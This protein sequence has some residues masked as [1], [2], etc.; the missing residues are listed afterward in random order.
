[1]MLTPSFLSHVAGKHRVADDA[2]HGVFGPLAGLADIA[3][4]GAVALRRPAALVEQAGDGEL[5]S[6]HRFGAWVS[7]PASRRG[8][9]RRAYLGP[10]KTHL[11]PSLSERLFQETVLRHSGDSFRRLFGGLCQSPKNDGF[12]GHDGTSICT[13][14]DD[15]QVFSMA[16]Q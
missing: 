4:L 13:H 10:P 7:G 8:H 15:E 3:V 12:W 9:I 14:I 6:R 2:Q 11:E 5:R 1:M 16:S